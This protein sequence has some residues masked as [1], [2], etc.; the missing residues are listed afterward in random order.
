MTILNLNVENRRQTVADLGIFP[1]SVTFDTR[2]E[3]LRTVDSDIVVGNR[4]ALI[5]CSNE[6]V[7]SIVSNSY[8]NTNTHADQFSKMEEMIINSKLELSGLTRSVEASPNGAKAFVRY[9]FP[10][11]EI[12]VGGNGDLVQLEMLGRNS[13]DLSWPS[14]FEAG[15]FRMVCLNGCVFGTVAAVGK[16]RHTKYSNIDAAII[17]MGKCLESFLAETDK[18]NAWRDIKIRDNEAY[19]VIALLSG[20]KYAI[21][22]ID[23]VT[24]NNLSVI[25]ALE[26]H[27]HNKDGSIRKGSSLASIWN[28]Y[29]TV[30]VPSM[31]RNLWSLYN[32]LTDWA[33][34]HQTTRKD[35]V[36]NI[37]VKSVNAFDNIRRVINTSRPFRLAA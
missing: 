5:N 20:N 2:Y 21:K 15:A 27:T 12:D 28:I 26:E 6:E 16:V 32:S 13:I 17:S 19:E 33:S 11:H 37:A 31:G 14:V 35:N 3:R 1:E 30:Y 23:L 24:S 29:S 7:V 10:A 25:K 22:D 9:R 34:H 4:N 18:W 36:S 8:L